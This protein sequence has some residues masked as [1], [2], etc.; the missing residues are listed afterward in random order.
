M[1]VDTAR[2]VALAVLKELLEDGRIDTVHIKAFKSQQSGSWRP[3]SA[4]LHVAQYPLSTFRLHNVTLCHSAQ[5]FMCLSCLISVAV[6][7]YPFIVYIH[8]LIDPF[9]AIQLISRNLCN[10]SVV[11]ARSSIARVSWTL[12][13]KV[14]ELFR[15]VTRRF[16]RA[17]INSSR[18]ITDRS[19]F[20]SAD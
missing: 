8:L 7:K 17:T 2:E 1:G 10:E 18:L 4:A 15:S 3:T 14:D 19:A 9:F 16:S 12:A 11:S 20:D 5:P 6:K 13:G